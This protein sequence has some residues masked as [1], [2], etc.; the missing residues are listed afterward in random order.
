MSEIHR[1]ILALDAIA[2]LDRSREM[3]AALSEAKRIHSVLLEYRRTA[4]PTKA[5]ANNT[6]NGIDTT[7]ARLSSFGKSPWI[8]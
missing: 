1:V 5:E 3:T 4:R 7:R 6:R 2:L 8:N